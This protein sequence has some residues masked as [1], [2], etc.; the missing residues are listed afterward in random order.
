M[1]A[2]GIG[3]S[4]TYRANMKTGVWLSF[5][6]GVKGDYESL[7]KWLDAR[8]ARECGDSVAYLTFEYQEDVFT[9]I[10]ISLHSS[11][12]MND[13]SRFY[14]IARQAP[15]DKFRGRFVVGKRKAAPWTGY[16]PQAEEAP[17]DES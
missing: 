10:A 12:K 2:L 16:G 3:R 13:A 7:Y 5:D 8:K 17:P 9:E 6:L 14:L 15:D 4:L 1:N 11:I